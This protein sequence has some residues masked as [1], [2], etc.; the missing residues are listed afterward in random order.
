MLRQ[1]CPS[2]EGKNYVPFI[3]SGHWFVKRL[4]QRWCQCSG[5]IK[6]KTMDLQK[7]RKAKKE[8]KQRFWD[9]TAD[10]VSFSNPAFGN[11]T[12]RPLWKANLLFGLNFL[13]N[14]IEKANQSFTRREICILSIEGHQGYWLFVSQLPTF[15]S[16]PTSR[17]F[18]TLCRANRRFQLYSSSLLVRFDKHRLRTDVYEI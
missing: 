14:G 9:R 10:L 6:E 7:V 17:C 15:Y 1:T 16:T 18:G 2:R 4:R 3:T 5:N 12:G 8:V 13:V 11:R